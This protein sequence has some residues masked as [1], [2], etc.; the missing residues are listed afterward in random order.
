MGHVPTVAIMS[1]SDLTPNGDS[2]TVPTETLASWYLN[3]FGRP[4]CPDEPYL[5]QPNPALCSGFL[6]APDII[7]TA[8]HCAVNQAYLNN[9]AVVFGFVMLDPVNAV[10]TIDASEV[11]LCT[12]I[13]ARYE[14]DDADWALIRLD[15]EVIG[16][17]PIPVRRSGKVADNQALFTIGYPIGLPRKYAANADVQDNL[18][19]SRFAANLDSYIG[20]SGS[21]IFNSNTNVVEGLLFDGNI[22]FVSDGGCDRSRVCPDSGCP[23]WEIITRTTEFSEYIPSYDVYLGT[24]PNILAKV[25]ENIV[26]PWLAIGDL[27]CGRIYYWQVLSKSFCG[28][29]A[30][31]IW[32]FRTAETSDVDHSCAVDLMDFAKFSTAWLNEPCYQ[33]NSWCLGMDLDFNG[34][35]DI[36]DL[37]VLASEWLVNK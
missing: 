17:M 27:D 7:A 6:V 19:L 32:T 25:A 30:S 18:S 31:P 21:P 29:T 14:A 33:S 13:I 10:T 24:D 37:S 20:S 28:T 26:N 16:H 4:L 35:V 23:D 1:I 9:I 8:G 22:D 36:C 11:Y 5:N 15:R 34:R 2:Y 3:T 12:E